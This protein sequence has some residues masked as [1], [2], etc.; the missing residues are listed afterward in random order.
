[1]TSIILDSVCVTLG[2][3]RVVDGITA[4]IEAGEWLTLIGP[5]G[6][7]KS[8]L[9]N[10]VA[11]TLRPSAGSVEIL[12]QAVGRSS[13]TARSRRGLRR[14][15]QHPALFG[16]LT[17]GEN[18]GIALRLRRR[19]GEERPEWLDGL[20]DDLGLRSWLGVV[21]D[22]A[23]YPVQKLVEMVRALAT[24]PKLLLTDEPAAGLPSTDRDRLAELLSWARD[25]LSCSIVLIEHDMPLVFRLADHITVL[26]NGKRIADG[27]PDEIRAHPE[28]VQAYF[29]TPV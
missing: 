13:P 23:P 11:G 1:V 28:V 7:G 16:S 21:V 10:V 26:S 22:S 25:H 15:F 14:T 9:V 12:G 5:N 24:G 29:G 2:G 18:L 8:T 20:L 6:A 4:E 27:T 17:I 3:K 19:G